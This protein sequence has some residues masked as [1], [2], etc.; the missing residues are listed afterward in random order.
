MENLAGELTL[1]YYTLKHSISYRCMDC[2]NKLAQDIY[3]DVYLAKE[4]FYGWTKAD[5]IV[6]NV[7]TPRSV[8]YLID[9]LKDST[10]FNNFFLLQLMPSVT[11]TK[12]YSQ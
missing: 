10:G 6:N 8:Q 7:L 12:R 4:M 2:A 11:R 5:A 3:S 1:A 9:A